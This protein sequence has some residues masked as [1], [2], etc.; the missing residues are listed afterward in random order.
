MSARRFRRAPAPACD[1]G[2]PC[3]PCVPLHVLP[4]SSTRERYP[5]DA[6]PCRPCSLCRA[7]CLGP[8]TRIHDLLLPRSPP[9]TRCSTNTWAATDVPRNGGNSQQYKNLGKP[10]LRGVG[11][12]ELEV[13]KRGLLDGNPRLLS[14][15]ARGKPTERSGT[16]WCTQLSSRCQAV[17]NLFPAEQRKHLEQSR[18]YRFSRHCY[19]DRMN[20]RSRFHTAGVGC[21]AQ[22]GLG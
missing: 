21:G 18:T 4:R 10:F 13:E 6:P 3:R 15:F 11:E 14:D 16:G 9:R 7:A 1:D 20:Q 12:D 8:S 2:S 19:T 22:C 5:S 17:T